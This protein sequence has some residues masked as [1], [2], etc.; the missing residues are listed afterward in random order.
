MSGPNLVPLRRRNGNAEPAMPRGLTEDELASTFT[1]RHGDELRYVAAWGAWLRW[2]GSSWHRENTLAAF[3]MARAVCRDAAA[4]LG[5]KQAKLR[6]K[7]LAASTRSAVENMAR[8]DRAHASTTEQWDS[9][10][11]AVGTPS[12]AA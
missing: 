10:L 9:D 1:E 7:I 6:A 2:C 5:P 11:F 12:R 3:D 4:E 8:A